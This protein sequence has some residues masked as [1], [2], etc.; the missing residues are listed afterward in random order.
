MR[1]SDD[2]VEEA[3]PMMRIILMFQSP[4]TLKPPRFPSV[5]LFQLFIPGCI[6]YIDRPLTPRLV[7]SMPDVASLFGKFVGNGITLG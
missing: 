4:Q 7:A 1:F 2:R 6:I 5:N 3:E